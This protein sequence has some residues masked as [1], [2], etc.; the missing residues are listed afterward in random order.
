M[1]GE[2]K[3][4]AHLCDFIMEHP[5]IPPP[6]PLRERQLWN[7]IKRFAKAAGVKTVYSV[8]L[9]FYAFQRKETPAWAKNIILGALA[10][11]ISPLDFLPDLTPVFGF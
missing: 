8:L 2:A 5:V 10:Y 6:Q 4:A 3:P 1:G 7:K 9:L 11:F